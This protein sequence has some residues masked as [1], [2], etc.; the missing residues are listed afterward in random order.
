M[1]K[2]LLLIISLFLLVIIA[3][4]NN[5]TTAQASTEKDVTKSFKDTKKVT[6]LV[7]ELNNWSG[8]QYIYLLKSKEKKTITL[9]DINILNIAALNYY[10]PNLGDYISATEKGILTR[11]QL[12]FGKE[13]SLDLL[14]TYEDEKASESMKKNEFI[15]KL[16]NGGLKT[17]YGD[18]GMYYP[19]M[20]LLKITKA[21]AK[22]Y[23]IRVKTYF[24]NDETK[25]K[26]K[27]GY[28]TITINKSTKSDYG[29]I[30]SGI[31]L[32]KTK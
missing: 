6:K 8:Y 3:V 11:T 7:N 1:K 19:K 9:T 10:E 30:I 27:Y 14:N 24:V 25:K 22:T 32:Q 15:C 18:W 28:T 2:K 31:K 23:T 16:T 26:D 20:K 12:L 21:D 17:L 4:S 13:P 29:Y 5:T